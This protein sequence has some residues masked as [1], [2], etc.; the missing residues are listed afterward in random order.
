MERQG[1]FWK[2][3]RHVVGPSQQKS[4]QVT[5]TRAPLPPGSSSPTSPANKSMEAIQEAYD[6]GKLPDPNDLNTAATGEF[7][8]QLKGF[9]ERAT[10]PIRPYGQ[11]GQSTPPV[12]LRSPRQ[13]AIH[14]M[15]VQQYQN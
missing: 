11:Q 13:R 10:N 2:S 3:L 14:N 4:P 5:H 6:N 12:T 9:L 8:A 15:I 1:Q 7:N